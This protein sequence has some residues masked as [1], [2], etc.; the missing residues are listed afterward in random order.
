MVVPDPS[1]N[2][3]NIASAL[4]NYFGYAS[5][6]LVNYDGTSN[7]DVVEN[8]IEADEPVIFGNA[9]H[10]WVCDGYKDQI[11]CLSNGMGDEVLL[12]HMNWG[13][14]G[15]QDGWFYFNEFDP[16]L[17]GQVQNFYTGSEV[18]VNIQP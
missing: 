16:T 10:A 7:Y 17:N 18:V 12:F 13:W 8:N 14:D 2:M 5:V 9:D 3:N 11:F 6:Q 4:T 1:A 15:D